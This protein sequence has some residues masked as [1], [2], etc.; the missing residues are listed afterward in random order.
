MSWLR[1]QGLVPILTGRCSVVLLFV[2][3]SQH[4]GN[5]WLIGCQMM[6]GVQMFNGFVKL[7][8]LERFHAFVVFFLRF[9]GKYDAGRGDISIASRGFR[10][11]SNDYDLLSVATRELGFNLGLRVSRHFHIYS[12]LTLVDRG[13]NCLRAKSRPG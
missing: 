13:E 9:R 8:S 10:L 11:Q 6:C 7:I 12:V 3:R 1:L 5:I 4:V 2:N